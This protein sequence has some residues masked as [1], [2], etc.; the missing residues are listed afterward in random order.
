[1]IDSDDEVL[2]S[3]EDKL[4]DLEPSGYEIRC[5]LANM[6]AGPSNY[7]HRDFSA[8]VLK[9]EDIME[10]Y[11]LPSYAKQSVCRMRSFALLFQGN[12]GDLMLGEPSEGEDKVAWM[13]R[14]AMLMGIVITRI[15]TFLYTIVEPLSHKLN[16]DKAFAATKFLHSYVFHHCN[17]YNVASGKYVR[18]KIEDAGCIS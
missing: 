7:M 14:R 1:M 9:F 4:T 2:P 13:D 17:I 18:D 6:E 3:P 12:R 5:T 11:P 16:N 8:I 15:A 10:L